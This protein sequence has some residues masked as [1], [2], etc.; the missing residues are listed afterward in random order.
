MSVPRANWDPAHHAC[1]FVPPPPPSRNQRWKGH[2]RLRVGGG[3]GG[4]NSDDWRKS[5]V[6]CILCNL[7]TIGQLITPMPIPNYTEIILVTSGQQAV[8]KGGRWD[9]GG[10]ERSRLG[11]TLSYSFCWF[12]K[13]RRL[14]CKNHCALPVLMNCQFYATLQSAFL[15]ICHGATVRYLEA[16]H[17]FK[18]NLQYVNGIK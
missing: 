6:L 4:P 16:I 15:C 2:T 7:S 10:G 18:F 12:C 5:L 9:G 11:N 3:G 8:S 1:K 17:Y 14:S 13:S